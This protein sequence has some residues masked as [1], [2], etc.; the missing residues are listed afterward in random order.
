VAERADI[1]QPALVRLIDPHDQRYTFV[2]V[3]QVAQVLGLELDIR[4]RPSH[5]E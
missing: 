5:S 4:L 1:L 2:S 3:Q